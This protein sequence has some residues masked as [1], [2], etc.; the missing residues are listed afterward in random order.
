MNPNSIITN[1]NLTSMNNEELDDLMAAIRD[2]QNGRRQNL[3]R[4]A[5]RMANELQK[6]CDANNIHM[7]AWIKNEYNCDEEVDVKDFSFYG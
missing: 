1:I 6:Y 5:E 7:T 2:E 3:V 4:E